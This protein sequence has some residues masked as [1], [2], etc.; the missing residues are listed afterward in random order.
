MVGDDWEMEDE[1][2]HLSRHAKTY[3]YTHDEV[4]FNYVMPNINAALG[5]AQM[6]RLKDFVAIKRRIAKT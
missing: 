4:G 2:R 3:P 5:A 1:V 6:A